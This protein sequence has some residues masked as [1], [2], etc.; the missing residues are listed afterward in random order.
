MDFKFFF[1]VIIIITVIMGADFAQYKEK[2][3]DMLKPISSQTQ[4]IEGK[5]IHS[6]NIAPFDDGSYVKK[7]NEPINKYETQYIVRVF[8]DEQN[9]F[10]EKTI[11][12][13]IT[14]YYTTDEP[15]IEQYIEK[16]QHFLS[17]T[18]YSYKIYIPK[19][20]DESVEKN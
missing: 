15:H 13:E 16:E 7:D 11:I 9:G 2:Y 20:I 18:K 17:D 14:Y 4:I 8:S 1:V 3:E 6:A 5:E 10:T 19:E 12:G